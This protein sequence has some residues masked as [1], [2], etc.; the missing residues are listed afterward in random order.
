MKNLLDQ[1]LKV[2][3]N[4]IDDKNIDG[5]F[6]FFFNFAGAKREAD[7]IRYLVQHSNGETKTMKS[8]EVK[9]FQ[10]AVIGFLQ[11]K[12]KWHPNEDT[13]EQYAVLVKPKR[14]PTRVVCACFYKISF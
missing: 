4:C 11:S 13:P 6:Q 8:V 12:I 7:G 14:A 9:D 3:L 5:K 10:I 1:L 2:S